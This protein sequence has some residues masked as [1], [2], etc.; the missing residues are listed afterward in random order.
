MCRCEKPL[1]NWSVFVI[2]CQE[3]I[4]IGDFLIKPSLAG[5]DFTYAFQKFIKII[6]TEVLSLFEP[7][8]I[9]YKTFDNEVLQGFGGPDTKLRTLLAVDPVSD[10][11]NDVKVVIFQPSFD[12][13]PALLTNCFQNGNSCVPFQLPRIKNI[14]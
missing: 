1:G 6:F 7:F 10:C 13:A 11:N 9:Q 12:V 5:L 8:V 3:C 2:I 4:N 14:S